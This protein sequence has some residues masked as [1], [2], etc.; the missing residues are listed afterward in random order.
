MAKLNEAMAQGVLFFPVA[1][2]G[3]SKSELSMNPTGTVKSVMCS[4]TMSGSTIKSG[5]VG[6]PVE[7]L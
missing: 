5:I 6:L 1:P 3:T 2:D 4:N 7:S